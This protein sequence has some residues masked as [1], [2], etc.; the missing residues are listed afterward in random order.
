[1]ATTA[2][3]QLTRAVKKS[4]DSTPSILKRYAY[5]YDAAGN[6]TSEQIDD[7][8]VGASHN[9]L[10]R[11]TSQQP[12]GAIRVTGTVNEA[13]Y[14]HAF[15]GKPQRCLRLESSTARP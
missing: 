9:N 5:A 11:L 15:R 10:N 4:T 2:A 12:N 6:R 14:G 8:V 7:A 1:M 13:A 3:E